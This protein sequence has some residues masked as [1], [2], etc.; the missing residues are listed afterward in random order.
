MPT[1]CKIQASRANGITVNLYR[2]VNGNGIP[3]PGGAD[4]AAVGTTTTASGGYYLFSG[5]SAGNY[6]VEFV[7]PSGQVLTTRNAGVDDSIDSDPDLVTGLTEIF[8]LVAGQTDLRWD[9]GFRPIDLEVDKTVNQPTPPVGTQVVFT[10]LVRNVAGFSTATGVEVTD[11]LPAGMTYSSATASQ[12]SYDNSSG[13]WTVGTLAGGSSATL[14]I[15]ATVNTSLAKTNTAEV[16][17]ANEQDTDST[18]GNHVPSEDDQDSVTITPPPFSQLAGL[19]NF[20]WNDLDRDGLQE[21][22]EPGVGNVTVTLTGGGTDA[23]IGTP[24]DT[25]ASATTS[26]SGAYAFIGLVPGT[27]YRLTFSNLPSGYVLTQANVGGDDTIDSDANPANGQTTIVTLTSGELNN[28]LDAGLVTS[29]SASSIG[30]FVWTDL[31]VNGLQDGGEPGHD[32]VT[33]NLYRDVNGNGI[34]EPGGADGA[35]IATTVTAGGGSYLFGGLSA[36]NYFVQFQPPSGQVFTTANVGANDNIDSDANVATGLTAVFPLAAGQND[37]KWDAGLKPIDLS[38]TKTVDNA[39][40][41][42]GQTVIYQITVGNAAGLSTATGVTVTDLLPPGVTFVS[43]SA[44]QGTYDSGTGE[45]TVGTVAGGSS[46]TLA[47]TATVDPSPIG[48]VDLGDLTKY[49]FFIGDGRTDANWQGAT[50]GFVGDVAVNGVVAS[51]RTS[52]GVPYAG[53]IYT[54]DTTLSAWQNIV[55]QNAGQAFGSTGNTTLIDNLK[56]QINAAFTQINGLTVTPGYASR[57]ATSLDNLNTQNGVD[58]TFV[59]NV[60]SGFGISSQIDITGDAG[61][62]FILRWD[63]DANFADGYEGQ[64]KF[65]SGG[66]IVPHGGL[67]PSNFIHVAGD[68]NSSGGGSTPPPPY[69]QGPRYDDGQG[70]LITGGSNFSGGGFF[71]GYWLTTGSPDNPADGTWSVPYGQSSSMSNGIFVGGWYTIATKFSMTSGT[72]GVYVSPPGGGA[73]VNTAEVTQANQPDTDSTPGNGVPTEDDQDSVAIQSGAPF[74]AADYGPGVS[75]PAALLAD[76]ASLQPLVAEALARW[77]RGGIG[78]AGGQAIG[79]G[80]V[81]RGRSRRNPAGRGK[82]GREPCDAGC[83]RRRMG[84]VHGCHAGGRFGV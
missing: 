63:T 58:E 80:A 28:T 53:T 16:T 22:G 79:N 7:R 74:S 50:K 1:V 48:G 83:R 20:V 71:T 18:P 55:N 54:N 68:I 4:G 21:V 10:V 51:E 61:D 60:T 13:V 75:D 81:L 27:Q 8:P 2:D 23:I 59:I 56:A 82:P 12:G 57:S 65:Q 31:N 44:S 19:G 84:L 62:V 45:W 64:V 36:G 35:A 24:D 34:A 33:V 42:I 29:G 38:L 37:L 39:N 77:M 69:P 78:R 67:K 40:P 47:L 30:N 46:A 9:A 73:I 52:G 17:R 70:A 11:L 26:G 32:G 76:T 41:S 6:F 25:T 72:S 49:L 66:A 15:T 3:E 5:L 14:A 43:A